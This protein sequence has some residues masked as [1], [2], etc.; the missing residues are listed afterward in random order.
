MSDS[1]KIS[2]YAA[3]AI[4][5]LR[6]SCSKVSTFYTAEGVIWSV[7]LRTVAEHKILSYSLG[8]ILTI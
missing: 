4:R 3:V 1:C 7:S 8:V 5:Y 6:I 2:K